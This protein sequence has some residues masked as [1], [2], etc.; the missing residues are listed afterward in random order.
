[1][2]AFHIFAGLWSAVVV[3]LAIATPFLFYRIQDVQH[4]QNDALRAVICRAEH[5]VQTQPGI[6][7]YKRLEA[8]KFYRGALSD[9]HLKPCS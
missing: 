9:A 1:M 6:P 4:H 3:A 8:I 5:V 2:K 7:A